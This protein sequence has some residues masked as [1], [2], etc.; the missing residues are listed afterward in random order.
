[1]LGPT[2]TTAKTSHT[3]FGSVSRIQ[4]IAACAARHSDVLEYTICRQYLCL[5]G[6]FP[7][8]VVHPLHVIA[9]VG[10]AAFTRT[11]AMETSV[12]ASLAHHIASFCAFPGASHE[13]IDPSVHLHRQTRLV[14]DVPR[15]QRGLLRSLPH[16]V[17][18]TRPH[19]RRTTSR[20]TLHLDGDR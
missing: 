17:E 6:T 16:L 13:Q 20:L 11:R 18:P 2:P 8:I 12:I 10:V 9:A 14:D 1:M 4:S 7:R 19:T 3:S 15:R 5:H